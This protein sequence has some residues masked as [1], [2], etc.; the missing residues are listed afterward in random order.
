[1]RVATLARRSLRFHWRTNLAVTLGVAVGSTTLI[2]ALMVGDS[3]QASLREIALGRLGRI[4]HALESVRF[5]RQEL[6]DDLARSSLFADHFGES[7]PVIIL[8]GGV[9][10]ADSR[11]R[12]SRVNVFGID[13][14]FWE[15][16]PS[17]QAKRIFA[18]PD[19]T[20]RVMPDWRITSTGRTVVLNERLAHELG[21]RVGDDVLVRVGR[22]QAISPETLLGRRD[23]NSVNMRLTVQ[24]V[25]PGRGFGAFSLRPDQRVPHNAYVPLATLQQLVKQPGRINTILVS[26]QDP[27]QQQQQQQQ[28]RPTPMPK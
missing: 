13:A 19:R 23:Q 8:R 18:L 14:R 26:G 3:M 22:P 28:H 25:I 24:A 6:A 4:D 7:V 11:A 27:L 10:H 2:G 1:M 20:P 15:L 16:D 9:T 12:V 17:T 5:V 21:A